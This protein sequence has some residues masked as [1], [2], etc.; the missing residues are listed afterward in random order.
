MPGVLRRKHYALAK[1]TVL[2]EFRKLHLEA[3]TQIL[4][5]GRV[6]KSSIVGIYDARSWEGAGGKE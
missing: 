1:N 6:D 2:K 3:E 5:S 4:G